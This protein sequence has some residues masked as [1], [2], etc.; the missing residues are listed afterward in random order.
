MAAAVDSRAARFEVGA[1]RPVFEM[2]TQVRGWDATADGQ[3]FLVNT[4]AEEADRSITLV[5]NWTA[6]L[7]RS[8]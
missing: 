2:H 8:R 7:S 3:R 4:V 6:A 5:V 1:V